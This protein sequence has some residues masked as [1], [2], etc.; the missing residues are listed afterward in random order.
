MQVG[1]RID[2]G[3]GWTDGLKGFADPF[4]QSGVPNVLRCHDAI[5]F[6]VI[7]THARG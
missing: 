6:C 1:E 7:H 5:G 2:K 3:P 4:G